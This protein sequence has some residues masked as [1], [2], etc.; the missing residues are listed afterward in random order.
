MK[1]PFRGWG[2][3]IFWNHTIQKNGSHTENPRKCP[4]LLITGIITM[5]PVVVNHG[6]DSRHD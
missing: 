6:Y 3:D 5:I 4:N 1:T 2:M